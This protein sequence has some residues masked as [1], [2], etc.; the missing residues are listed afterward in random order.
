MLYRN[1][2]PSD[3]E[4]IIALHVEE[5]RRAYADILSADHLRSEMPAQKRELWCGR[6]QR[7]VDPNRLSVTVAESGACRLVGFACFIFEAD[8]RFGSYLHNLYVASDHQRRGIARRLL[9]E[10]ISRFSPD[11]IESPVHL[12]VYEANDTAR[13]LYDRLGGHP[14]ERFERGKPA[15]ELLRYQWSSA[16]EL[17]RRARAKQTSLEIESPAM[18]R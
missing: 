9:V 18:P 17:Q 13:A 7:E 1:A 2:R 10:G 8:D 5:Q 11:R 12:L 16:R 15:I 14:V 3:L 6:L 4:P